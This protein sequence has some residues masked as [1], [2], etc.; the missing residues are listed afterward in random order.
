MVHSAIQLS[1]RLSVFIECGSYND[2]NDGFDR[3]NFSRS[4]HNHSRTCKTKK[5]VRVKS[6][7]KS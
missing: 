5:I 4:K 1:M 7:W 6:P 2:R 3:S